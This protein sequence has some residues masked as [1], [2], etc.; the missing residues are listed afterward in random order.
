MERYAQHEEIGAG[1]S[2]ARVYRATRRSDECEVALK[3]FPGMSSTPAVRYAAETA[4]PVLQSLLHR[5]VLPLFEWF[6]DGTDICLVTPLAVPGSAPFTDAAPRLAAAAVAHVASEVSAGLEY[7]HS[8]GVLH[9]D[10]KPQNLFLVGGGVPLT[11]ES[12]RTAAAPATAGSMTVEAAADSTSA[13]TA[14]TVLLGDFGTATVLESTRHG[15]TGVGTKPYM[16]LEVLRDEDEPYDAS[17]DVW[18]LGATLLALSTGHQVA[19]VRGDRRALKR[20]TWTLDDAIAGLPEAGKAAWRGLGTS[21][22]GHKRM[23]ASRPGSAA[24]SCSAG[25]IPRGCRCPRGR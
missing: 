19:F 5:N 6:F 10:I 20:G 4:A 23:P 15:H 12:D 9:R 24:N 8:K 17:A 11:R 18:S 25:R 13:I 22:G 14:G 1:G 16:A 7:L 3:R 21:A 2:G